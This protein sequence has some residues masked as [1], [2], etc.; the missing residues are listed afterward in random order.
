[1]R[2]PTDPQVIVWSPRDGFDVATRIEPDGE[3][4]FYVYNEIASAAIDGDRLRPYAIDIKTWWPVPQLHGGEES[5][6]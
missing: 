1:M 3:D 4:H 6:E 5:T 2:P